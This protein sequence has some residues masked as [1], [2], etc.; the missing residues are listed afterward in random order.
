[1]TSAFH[2][3]FLSLR[4]SLIAVLWLAL[5]NQVVL[6]GAS[7]DTLRHDV[8]DFKETCLHIV[9]APLHASSKDWGIAAGAATVIAASSL[10]DGGVRHGMT[11]FRNRTATDIANVGHYFQSIPVLAA[12]TGGFY[13]LGL[14][15]DKPGLRRCGLELMEAQAIAAV[16][17][18]LVKFTVGRDRPYMNTG[19]SHFVGPNISNGHQSFF[20]GDVTVAFTQAS[21]IAAEA[22]SIPVTIGLY[23]LATSTAFQRLYTDKHWLSDVV[24]ASIWGTAVGLG[25]VYTNRHSNASAIRVGLSQ[26]GATLAYQW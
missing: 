4:L 21:V 12:T 2:P 23:G 11:S 25:V 15:D 26:Q 6:A 20:S 1:M 7:G 3:P 17:T 24:T 13:M 5:Q 19:P 14:L 9:K 8:R 10:A 16:G 22:K 18:Q